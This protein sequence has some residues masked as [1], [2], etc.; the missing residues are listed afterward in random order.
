MSLI[1]PEIQLKIPGGNRP[2]DMRFGNLSSG[3]TL[4]PY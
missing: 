3:F 1:R 4:S 2:S